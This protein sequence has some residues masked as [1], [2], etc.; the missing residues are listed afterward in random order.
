MPSIQ[1]TD[2]PVQVQTLFGSDNAIQN[3]GSNPIYLGNDTSVNDSDYSLLPGVSFSITSNVQLWAVCDT[4]LTS[5]LQTVQG[6]APSGTTNVEVSGPIDIGEVSLAPGSTVGIAGPV[7]IGSG[8]VNATIAPGST[9]DINSGTVNVGNP[10][11]NT[12]DAT[13]VYQNLSINVPATGTVDLGSI[14]FPLGTQILYFSIQCDYTAASTTDLAAMQV[15][16]FGTGISPS[17]TYTLGPE[18]IYALTAFGIGQIDLQLGSGTHAAA[19]T[20]SVTIL[21][22]N[23]PNLPVYSLVDMGGVHA[24]GAASFTPTSLPGTYTF[25]GPA[26]ANA[27]TSISSDLPA[28]NYRVSIIPVSTVAVTGSVTLT[29]SGMQGPTSDASITIMDVLQA[30]IPFYGEVTIPP[31]CSNRLQWTSPTSATGQLICLFVSEDFSN[32]IY[33]PL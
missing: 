13:V 11:S 18:T 9:V 14:N 28:G 31:A 15:Q 5:T 33:G 2:T 16:W 32:T 4:G 26:G 21:A 23:A 25:V 20:A 19:F 12:S 22:F 27:T 24:G 7:D 10:I 3:S 6:I 8:N 30:Q 1:V 17:T 29:A